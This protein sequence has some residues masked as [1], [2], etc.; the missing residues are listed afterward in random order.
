MADIHFTEIFDSRVEADAFAERYLR[1][2]HPAGYGTR[3]KVYRDY[4][5]DR[6][7][8]DAYRQHSCD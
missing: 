1:T 5:S 4:Q 6:W 8:A 2:F 3:V 7:I